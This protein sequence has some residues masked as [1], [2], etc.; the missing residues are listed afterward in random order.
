MKKPA[1]NHIRNLIFAIP[2]VT[3]IS[4]YSQLNGYNLVQVDTSQKYQ[5]IKGFGGSLA[6]YEGWVTSHPNKSGIYNA[7]FGELSLD[8]LRLRNAFD[9]DSTMID[10][11]R[12]FVEAADNIRG[13]PVDGY[14]MGSAGIFEK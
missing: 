10:R 1:F 7:L 4:G 8:I 6:Y 12:E 3:C 13:K 11:A 2:I 14:L 5:T 9:Y